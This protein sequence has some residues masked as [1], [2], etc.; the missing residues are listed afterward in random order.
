LLISYPFVLPQSD[1]T[2]HL[3]PIVLVCALSHTLF[4]G[5]LTAF[6]SSPQ[7]QAFV[8]LMPFALQKPARAH[9]AFEAAELSQ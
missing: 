8:L 4:A 5:H 7:M 2:E 1:N 6:T 3:S 9:L